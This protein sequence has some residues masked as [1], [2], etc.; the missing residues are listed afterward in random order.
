VTGYNLYVDDGFYGDF[1]SVFTG[2]SFENS[3]TVEGL[4]TG[5][6]YRFKVSGININGEGLQSD[7]ITIY[8]CARPLLVSA[9]TKV[10]TTVSSI[11]IAWKEPEANGCPVTGFLLMRDTGSNDDLSLVIDQS[12]IQE[13]PS[14]R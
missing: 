4:V 7:E 11:T 9:P 10:T 5:L 13:R 14:L 8:A 6:P 1:T 3:H 12:L 2:S